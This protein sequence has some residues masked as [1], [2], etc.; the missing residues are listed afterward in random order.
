MNETGA[1]D[2]GGAWLDKNIAK[3]NLTSV[4]GKIFSEGD[5]QRGGSW[6]G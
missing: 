5:R 4:F 6:C 3:L 2:R 1:I